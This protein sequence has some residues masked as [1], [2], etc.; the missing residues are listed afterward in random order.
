MRT[1]E[2]RLRF[3]IAF[4]HADL[5]KMREGDMLNLRED[6]SNFAHHFKGPFAPEQ[7]HPLEPVAK[8]I[9]KE[10]LESM[11]VSSEVTA[12][13]KLQREMTIEELRSLQSEM[14]SVLWGVVPG[15]SMDKIRL[16]LSF[17]S[18]TLPNPFKNM[19]EIPIIWV[20]GSTRDVVLYELFTLLRD[21][22]ETKRI[23]LCPECRK[24]FYKVKRQKYCSQRCANR[25]YMRQYRATKSEQIS[26]SNHKQYEKRT[27]A[28][29]GKTVKVG[30]RPR[31]KDHGRK[32]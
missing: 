3:A 2:E 12:E 31:R 23:Q 21:S 26:E 19:E 6:L 1:V 27:K 9:S 14:R 20:F 16:N 11:G 32:S 4:S 5:K 22:E 28:K 29:T 24:I 15:C 8:Q 30:R 10:E 17:K 25:D 7:R 18:L 13:I